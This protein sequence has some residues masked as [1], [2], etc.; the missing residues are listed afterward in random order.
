MK[1]AIK[2]TQRRREKQV[3]YNRKLG[4]TPTTIVKAISDY[5][6]PAQPGR[7]SPRSYGRNNDKVII[8][9]NS[10]KAG[11]VEQLTKL[12][13]RASRKMEYEKALAYREQIQK[14]KQEET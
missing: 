6:L 5:G 1:I 3:I 8:F 14:L 7:N 12:M 9:G 11:I 2:E 13:N 10:R 4:I